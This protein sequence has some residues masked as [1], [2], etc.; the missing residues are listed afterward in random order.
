MAGEKRAVVQES[1][2]AAVFQDNRGGQLAGNY[3]AELAVAGH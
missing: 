2:A 3:P 1:H